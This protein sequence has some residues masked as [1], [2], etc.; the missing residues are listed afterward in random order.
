MARSKKK[1]RTATIHSHHEVEM[2]QH[3]FIIRVV[4]ETNNLSMEP[5]N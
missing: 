1:S 4:S 2:G 5:V 3:N